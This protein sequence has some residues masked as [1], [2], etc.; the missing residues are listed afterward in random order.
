MLQFMSSQRV[1]L[2]N[3]SNNNPSN[4]EGYTR[5]Q[6]DL[7]EAIEMKQELQSPDLLNKIHITE[8]ESK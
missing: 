8:N 5:S 3:S 6:P 1:E 7:P 4:Q 2:N